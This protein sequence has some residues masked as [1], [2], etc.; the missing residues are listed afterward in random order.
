MEVFFLI[1]TFILSHRLRDRNVAG[2]S[3]GGS[4]ELRTAAA[5]ASLKGSTDQNSR[6][7]LTFWENTLLNKSRT[8]RS[9]SSLVT[10]EERRNKSNH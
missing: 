6:I 9:I 2:L 10:D 5:S 3:T 4:R 7:T 8:A 1:K